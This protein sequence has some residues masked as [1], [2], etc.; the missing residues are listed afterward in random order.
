MPPRQTLD[1]LIYALVIL[2]SVIAVTLAVTS[3]AEFTD[4][5]N[6]YQQF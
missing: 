4:M 6:A 1:Y 5:K 3:P 2:L